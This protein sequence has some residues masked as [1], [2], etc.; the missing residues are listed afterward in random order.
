MLGVVFHAC[1]ISTLGRRRQKNQEFK[2]SFSY[3]VNL[4]LPGLTEDTMRPSHSLLLSLLLFPCIPLLC[5]LWCSLCSL[6]W[7]GTYH[8]P[9]LAFPSTGMTDPRHH[10]QLFPSDLLVF[11]GKCYF[12][13]DPDPAMFIPSP[14]E[15][16]WCEWSGG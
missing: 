3:I 2:G 9:A 7:A 10:I 12:C 13:G 11:L 1:N 14:M 4:K 16:V 15:V 6:V 5:P 8:P